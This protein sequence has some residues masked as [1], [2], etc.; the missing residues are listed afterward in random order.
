MLHAICNNYY[1]LYKIDVNHVHDEY[2]DLQMYE[3]EYVVWGEWTPL[4][5][6][7]EGR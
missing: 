5:L 6:H 4:T 3:Y 2:V 1:K 7:G